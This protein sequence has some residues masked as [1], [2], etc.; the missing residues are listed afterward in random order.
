[1]RQGKVHAEYV[2]ALGGVLWRLGNLQGAVIPVS[3]ARASSEPAAPH[4]GSH[5]KRPGEADHFLSD[6]TVTEDANRSS[7]Q[8]ARVRIVLLVPSTQPQIGDAV[9]N[10]AI[11]RQ[12]EAEREFCNRVGILARTIR[13]VNAP[14]RRS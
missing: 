8:S 4:D 2:A 13:H 3:I 1:M 10:A 5:A 11:E 6:A 14:L 9:W 12:D 7:E